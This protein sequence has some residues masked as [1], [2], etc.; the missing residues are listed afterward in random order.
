MTT[1]IR[2]KSFWQSFPRLYPYALLARWDRPIGIWLLFWPCVWG[3]LLAPSFRLLL[4]GEQLRFLALFFLGAV[5]MRGAGC[6]LNDL[7]D[8]HMDAEVARTKNRPLASGRLKPWQAILFLL[9]QLLVGAF[10]LLQLPLPAIFLGLASLPLIAAYPWMKRITYWP[11]LFLGIVFNAGVL[12]GYATL[13][14]HLSGPVLVLY[15]AAI[16]WT[17]AYDSVYAFLDSADDAKVGIK[18]TVQLWAGNSKMII[19]WLWV[20]SFGLFALSLWLAGGYGILAYSMVLVALVFNLA[21]HTYWDITNDGFTLT[22]FRLQSRI[23][24]VLALA[25]AAPLLF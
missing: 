13:E 9:L 17:L 11:Q 15:L 8:R 22:F 2:E 3:L 1:D 21:A 12:I 25:V 4:P 19:G 14:T 23:G 6:T 20:C 18:S 24:L 5:A 7:I 10:V 16:V